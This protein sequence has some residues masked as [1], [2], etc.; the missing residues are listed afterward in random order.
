[1]FF[2]TTYFHGIKSASSKTQ[3]N[4]FG[5]VRRIKTVNPGDPMSVNSNSEVY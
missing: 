4:T 2:L 5:D 3:A 1:M